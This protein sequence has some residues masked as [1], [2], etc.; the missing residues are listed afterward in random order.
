MLI[1]MVPGIEDRL[2]A[3]F[4][5]FTKYPEA[6]NITNLL[7]NIKTL[8][9]DNDS[10]LQWD[11]AFIKILSDMIK[12]TVNG[13]YKLDPVHGDPKILIRELQRLR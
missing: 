13:A 11:S 5:V 4:Y 6:T 12:K 9:V 7:E 10:S 3:I 8:Q 1:S 2:D